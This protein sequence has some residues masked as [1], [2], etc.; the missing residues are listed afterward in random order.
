MQL[1]IQPDGTVRSIYDETLNLSEFG[2]VIISRASHVEPD[3]HGQWWADLS[4]VAGPRLG[5]FEKRSTALT[6]ESHWLTEHWLS[7]ADC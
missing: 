4:P 5:P 1:I 3:A 6:A 7:P 2:T